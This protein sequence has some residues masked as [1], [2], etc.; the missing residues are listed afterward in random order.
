[1]SYDPANDARLRREEARRQADFRENATLQRE[2]NRKDEATRNANFYKSM[3]DVR[4]APAIVPGT[5]WTGRPHRTEEGGGSAGSAGSAGSGGL[6][7]L[8]SF[9]GGL[10]VAYFVWRRLGD[11]NP[12]H[13]L[14]ALGVGAVS[15]Y[16]TA[17]IVDSG[18]VR[19]L[20]KFAFF[21]SIAG[22]IL[23]LLAHRG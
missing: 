23:W 1:M 19:A 11:A 4:S 15:G 13:P 16:V 18:P 20:V 12:T 2:R 6:W 21:V 7:S 17:K 5:T 10:A 9:V 3:R 14:A 8:I 22:G